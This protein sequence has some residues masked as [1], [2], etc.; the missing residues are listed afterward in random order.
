[1]NTVI[2]YSAIE[3]KYIPF[4]S[5]FITGLNYAYKD[6]AGKCY[7]YNVLSGSCHEISTEK[8]NSLSCNAEPLQ[9]V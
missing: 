3:C 4:R 8:Y 7:F 9:G 5:G 1:M 6:K 2:A